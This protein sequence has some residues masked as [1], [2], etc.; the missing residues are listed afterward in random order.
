MLFPYG[1]YWD[2]TYLILIPGLIA[3]IWA[4]SRINR[5]YHEYSHIPAA[6]GWTGALMARKLLD[7]NGLYDV[8]VTRADGAGL[9]C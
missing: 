5:A 6:G 3:A 7:D 8:A 2:P 9:R 4:Q 1:F